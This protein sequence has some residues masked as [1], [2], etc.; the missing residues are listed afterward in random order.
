VGDFKTNKFERPV[1]NPKAI[2][3]QNV[4]YIHAKLNYI[5]SAINKNIFYNIVNF[6][7]KFYPC[8]R[9]CPMLLTLFDALH[10]DTSRHEK[11]SQA[12]NLDEQS[13]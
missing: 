7:E 2:F 13:V 8:Q 4:T 1:G 3:L 6:Y 5:K 11:N 12:V 9:L 10:R